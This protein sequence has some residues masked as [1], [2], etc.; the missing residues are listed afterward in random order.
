MAV[1]TMFPVYWMLL[2]SIL[3]GSAMVSRHPALSPIGQSVSFESYATVFTQTGIASWFAQSAVVTIGTAVLSTVISVFAAY[4]MSRFVI[5]GRK[6][7][8]LTFLM[9]RV[10]PGTV[11][12]L[13]FFVL[14]QTIGL[15]DTPASVILA[16]SAMIVPVTALVLKGYLDGIPRDIDEAALVDGCTR[17]SALWR[18]ILPISAPGLAACLGLSATSAWTG[19]LIPRTLLFSNDKWTIPQGIVSF[20][21]EGRIEWAELMAVGVLSVIP[22]A[23]IYWFLQP[24]LVSG[25]TAGGVK[26]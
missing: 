3:P 14:F 7:V 20:I 5:P 16:E 25:M 8:A 22:V 23:I 11:L 1:L 19:L 24:H 17:W 10:L 4:A 2:T 26:G 12:A 9:G 15:L 6:F 13:P 21:G 18:V